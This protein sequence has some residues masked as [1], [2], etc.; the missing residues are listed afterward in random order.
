MPTSISS[1]IQPGSNSASG[2]L[3][4][5]AK[6]G[7]ISS[8][9]EKSHRRAEEKKAS[10]ISMIEIVDLIR[11]AADGLEQYSDAEQRVGQLLHD[12]ISLLDDPEREFD[13]LLVSNVVSY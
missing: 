11:R 9:L 10:Q 1:H 6:V 5:P 13:S 2:H 12:C 8:G 3:L 7:F 4:I